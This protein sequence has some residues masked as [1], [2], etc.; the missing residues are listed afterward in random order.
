MKYTIPQKMSGTGSIHDLASE[1]WDRVIAGR[2]KYAVVLA[3]FYGGKGYT[4]HETAA[5][6]LDYFVWLIRGEGRDI[7]VDTGFN[8]AAG[9]LVGEIISLASTGTPLTVSGRAFLGT[10]KGR[11]KDWGVFIKQVEDADDK[12]KGHKPAPSQAEAFQPEP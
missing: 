11:H 6:D 10:L 12:I 1:H 9:P 2:G 7:L 4:T 3:S 8:E 5:A